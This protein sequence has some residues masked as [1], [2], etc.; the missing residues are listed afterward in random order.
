MGKLEQEVKRWRRRSLGHVQHTVL[1]TVATG[2]LILV[3][4]VPP[5][6]YHLFRGTHNKYRFTNQAKS[7]LV[8][9]AQKGHIVFEKRDGKSYA[10]ITSAGRKI[11]ERE[12]QYARLRLASSKEPWDERWRVVIFDIPE[13]RRLTRDQLRTVMRNAGF[14]RLQNSVW[15]YPY[16]CEDF[17]ALLKADLRVGRAVLYLIVDKIENDAHLK[18]YFNL[19]S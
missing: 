5:T 3:R 6:A 10:R 15:L 14:Y 4:A 13:Y 8:R 2:G 12:E 17:V 19:L 11:L 16:D 9:L 7:V 1:S 18:R